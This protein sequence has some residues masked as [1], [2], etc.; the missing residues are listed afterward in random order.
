[1]P[2]V[3]GCFYSW[4][5]FISPIWSSISM[6]LSSII[7][8]SFSHFLKCLHYDDS[9]LEVNA[10]NLSMKTNESRSEFIS[11]NKSHL[12]NKIIELTYDA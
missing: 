3:A 1:M 11:P 2:I 8:V 10:K 6:S 7:V 12:N 9:L 4:G 5:V